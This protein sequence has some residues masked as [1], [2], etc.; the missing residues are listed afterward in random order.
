MVFGQEV[1]RKAAVPNVV[2]EEFDARFVDITTVVWLHSSNDLY[3]ARFDIKKQSAQ[4]VF[5]AN[6]Y[7]LETEQEITYLELP[8]SARAFCKMNYPS[9]QAKKI[10]KVSTR[11]YGILYE[12]TIVGEGLRRD[13]S[14]DMHGGLIEQKETNLDEELAGAEDESDAPLKDKFGKLFKKKD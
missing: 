8:D 4:A 3:I 12:L 10:Q 7:W 1:V 2:I 11:K 5:E 9:Y 14:F 13:L 6:G